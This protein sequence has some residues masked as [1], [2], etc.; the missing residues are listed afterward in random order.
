GAAASSE[1]EQITLSAKF[2][3]DQQKADQ[4]Y[5]YLENRAAESVFQKDQFVEISGTLA[6]ISTEM[7]A[8]EQMTNLAERLGAANPAVGLSGA[9]D[10]L[11]QLAEGDASGLAQALQVPPDVL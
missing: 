3:G 8:L 5:N 2:Q 6:S 10:A 7:P 4:F 11:K 9:A 1:Y